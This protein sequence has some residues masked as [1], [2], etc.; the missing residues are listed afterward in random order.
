[1]RSIIA[2]SRAPEGDGPWRAAF[3]A[4]M[5]WFGRA[6]EPR[7]EPSSVVFGQGDGNLAN[8]LWDGER[9][10]LV[11]FEDSGQ[12]PRQATRRPRRTP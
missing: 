4:G 12:A 7:P 2:G 3:D 5:R 8:Y 1:M 11:D 10:R 6:T 9:V